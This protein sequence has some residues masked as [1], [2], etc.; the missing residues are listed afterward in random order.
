MF[1]ISLS[2]NLSLRADAQ[3]HSLFEALRQGDVAKVRSAIDGG[4]EVN[5]RDDDGNTLLM[6]TAVYAKPADLAFL[7]AHGADLNAANKNGHTALMRAMPDFAKIELLVEHGANVNAA[8]VD[9]TTPLMMAAR[10]ESAGDVVRYLV[11][12]GAALGATDRSGADA[13]LI[14]ATEGA[15]GNLKILLDAGMSGSSQRKNGGFPQQFNSIV[16]RNVIDRAL[17]DREGSTAL[18]AAAA[19]DCE[20]CVRLLLARGADAKAASK[21]GLTAL[22]PA[23]YEGNSAIVK[24]LLDA[25]APVNVADEHGFTPL[26]MAANSKNKNAEI[27]RLLLQ[28]GADIKPK[29]TSG[30]TAADWARIGSRPEIMKALPGSAAAPS[31]ASENAGTT[32]AIEPK[33]IRGAIERSVAL[34]DRTAP[35][36]F[37]KSGCISCH[38]VSIPMMALGEA[39]SR[40]YKVSPVS[41]AQMIKSTLAHLS[42][43]RDNLL[44]GYCSVPGMHTTT[45]YAAISLYNE[46]YHSDLFTDS[47][48]RCL[49]T[50]QQANGEWRSG[51]SRPPLGPDVKLYTVPALARVG[52]ASAARARGYLL[53]AKP[54][55]TDDYAYR[56]LGLSWTGT[57][58][59]RIEVAAR[60]LAAQQKPDGG[61]AQT[62]DM[63]SDAYAT[64]LALAAL[65]KVNE[66]SVNTRAYRHGVNYLLRIQEADGS[67]HVRTR[68]FGFQPYFES[69]FPHGHDQ[70]ISMA[71]TAWSAMALMPVAEPPST[72]VRQ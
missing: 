15:A 40:G 38:N 54:W 62:P 23:S 46:G 4:A 28:N 20:E 11:N 7:L 60:E 64:G 39:R 50:D 34:L 57:Q 71:A 21:S 3:S 47:V 13:V 58:P 41:A 14:A 65:A 45:T 61:W 70:W 53:A 35:A 6:Q 42:P 52:D 63:D 8:T 10:I 37:N 69:G 22:L 1:S 43:Q 33:D 44:S 56:L 48:V 51:G 24:L 49:I 36:F 17:R 29:D 72:P 25:G 59:D 55:T 12:K 30:R 27:V 32:V 5:S 68:A 18:M 26:M 16:N 9:D 66:K 67:W 2:S 31:G 19:A